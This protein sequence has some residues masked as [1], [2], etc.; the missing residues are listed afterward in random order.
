MFEACNKERY[1]V[2][3]F[4]RTDKV[5]KPPAYKIVDKQILARMLSMLCLYLHSSTLCLV[6]CKFCHLKKPLVR[7]A[8]RIFHWKRGGVLPF[9]LRLI[10]WCALCYK[11][12][13]KFML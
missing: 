4:Q 6:M 11:L 3:V 13:Y 12:C 8:P 10:Y 2:Y 7:R 9:R 5:W 1:K